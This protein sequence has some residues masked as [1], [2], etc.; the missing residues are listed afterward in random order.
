MVNV[1]PF[2]SAPARLLRLGSYAWRL[3]AVRRSQ[4]QA[5]PPGAQPRTRVLEPAVSK[6]ADCTAFEPPGVAWKGVCFERED[7]VQSLEAARARPAPA[8]A[9][10]EPADDAPAAE[11]PAA[12]APA[13]TSA[14][15]QG[16]PNSNPN[17]STR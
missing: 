12:A 14:P 4:E 17:V 9:A 11:P 1:P 2:A 7:L 10:A 5:G 3:W 6:A 16:N 8:Q 13:P 15:G